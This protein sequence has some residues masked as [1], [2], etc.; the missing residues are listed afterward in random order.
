MRRLTSKPLTDVAVGK[1]QPRKQRYDI[2]D[3]ALRGFSLRVSIAGTK[4][5]APAPVQ[6][7][8][9]H[10]PY[11]VNSST[12]TIAVF[13]NVKTSPHLRFNIKYGIYPLSDE[14]S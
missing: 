3:A 1:A 12:G 4:T 9:I 14:A 2:Y 7:Y 11:A 5:W 10:V 6:R 13:A 8:P